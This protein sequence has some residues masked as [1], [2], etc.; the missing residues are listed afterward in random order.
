MFQI[1]R[2]KYTFIQFQFLV[3]SNGWRQLLKYSVA[4]SHRL[5]IAGDPRTPHT[6]L[7]VVSVT[8]ILYYKFINANP[9]AKL[10]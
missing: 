5:L 7:L 3:N 4:A 8:H 2:Y 6:P 9:Q 10:L 1:Q